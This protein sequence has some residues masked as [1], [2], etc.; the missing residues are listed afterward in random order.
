MTSFIEVAATPR[1]KITVRLVGH[2]YVMTMPKGALTLKIAARAREAEEKADPTVMVALFDDWLD[3]GFGKKQGKALRA[4]M[5]D[6]DDA[7]DIPHIM[8]LI[9]KVAEVGT[10]NPTS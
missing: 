10:P 6:P 9:Q 2:E 7:L 1:E 5:D 4:R 3:A 8:E